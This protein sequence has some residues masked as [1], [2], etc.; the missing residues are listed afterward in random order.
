LA[1]RVRDRAR[2]ARHLELGKLVAISYSQIS[3]SG[4]EMEDFGWH[5]WIA[6]GKSL[7]AGAWKHTQTVC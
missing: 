6:G 4:I 5:P 3:G 2:R 7:D 1:T